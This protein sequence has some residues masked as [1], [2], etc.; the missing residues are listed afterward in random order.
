MGG[1]KDMEL[2]SLGIG[3]TG[4]SGQCGEEGKINLKRSGI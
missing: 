3:E 1:E 2:T 4:C